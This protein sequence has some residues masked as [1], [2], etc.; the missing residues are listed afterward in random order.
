[1]IS[2][3]LRFPV[4]FRQNI[5][6]ITSANGVVEISGISSVVISAKVIVGS[7]VSVVERCVVSSV[8]L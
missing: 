2:L 6:F 7:S 1:M 5:L 8:E 3:S 4:V